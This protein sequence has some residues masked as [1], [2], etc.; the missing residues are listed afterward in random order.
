MHLQ[1]YY[2]VWAGRR[3]GVFSSWKQCQC[4]ILDF[5]GARFKSFQT[6]PEAKAALNRRYQD[7]RNTKRTPIQTLFQ[8]DDTRPIS[9]SI[10]VSGTCNITTGE[11]EIQAVHTGSKHLVFWKSPYHDGTEDMAEFIAI[12]ETLKYLKL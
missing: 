2:T 12:V 5:K 7:R 11:V 1:K 3:T 6:L 10:T 9:N 8:T 4:Q